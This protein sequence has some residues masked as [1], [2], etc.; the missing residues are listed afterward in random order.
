MLTLVGESVVRNRILTYLHL[1]TKGKIITF[2]WR[3]LAKTTLSSV[4]PDK[5]C[6]VHH[7]CFISA[8]NI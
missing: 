6:R 1:S 8:K 7:L 4:L 3:N 5:L 2:L